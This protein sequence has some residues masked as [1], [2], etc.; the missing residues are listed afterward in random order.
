VSGRIKCWFFS[1]LHGILP[2]LRMAKALIVF[3]AVVDRTFRY[4]TNLSKFEA[5]L[6]VNHS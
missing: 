4:D 6:L 2:E 1:A 3:G 5:A